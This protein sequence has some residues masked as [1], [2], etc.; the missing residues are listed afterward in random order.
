MNGIIKILGPLLQTLPEGS[1]RFLTGYGAAS[2]ALALLDVVALGLVAALLPGLVGGTD[3]VLPVLGNLTRQG[4]VLPMLIFICLLIVLKGILAVLLL[5]FATKRFA[6]HEVAI[7]D[8]LFA[9]YLASPWEQRL[10]RNSAEIVRSVDVG[11]GITVSGVLMPAMTLFGELGTLAAV[12][13]VLFVAQPLIAVVTMVYLGLV[14]L[15]L[16]RVIS[17]RAVAIG[18]ENREWSNRTAKVLYEALGAL[19]EITLADRGPEVQEQVH[20]TRSKS[21]Q[22]RAAA[23]QISQIPRYVLETALV[24]GFALVGGVGLATGGAAG[25]VSA[26]GLFAIAGFRLIPSL[27]RMQAVQSSVNTSASFARQII[28]DIREGEEQMARNTAE[29]PQRELPAAAADIV[30]EHVSFTYPGAAAPA[31]RDIS[32]RIPAGSHVAF[33][34]SSGA[35][36]STMVD[37]L[38][39]LL[40][41]DGGRILV[42]GEPLEFVLKSWRRRIGYVPQEVS[43]FDASVAQNVALAWDPEKVDRPRVETALRRAQLLDTVLGREGGIDA[44][45][46][47]RGLALSGG[48]R[49]R[50][51]IARALYD[52]PLVL[53]MDEATSALDTATEAAVTAAINELH[54][55]VTVITVAHRLATIR[56]AD[57]VFFMR[58]GTVAAYGTFDDV[59]ARVPDFARQAALAGLAGN[60][61]EEGTAV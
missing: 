55:E 33:V 39:G 14:A 30:L 16:A 25:A 42:G 44:L 8:R 27:T 58:E 1:R 46:G 52:D 56:N 61:A 35:G 38:L 57:V 48:Q 12:V 40:E 34:G 2:A 47:E 15:L 36:K 50:L 22:A 54:G 3:V 32:I 24:V 29:R 7:G 17:P 10:G 5:R 11:V 13:V 45:V 6:R 19:K 31:L 26:I 18:R 43:L 21:A 41:P 51:G 59:V 4:L 28:Q 23:I 49:Q 20:G 53:V 37:V 60:E 9:A